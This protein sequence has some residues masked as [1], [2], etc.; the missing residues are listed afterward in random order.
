MS[1]SDEVERI[2][3]RKAEELRQREREDAPCEES[4]A[5][6]SD[7]PIAVD[8]ADHLAALAGRHDVL[9]VDFYADWCGPCQTMGPVVASIAAE[10]PAAVA[11]VD[12][13]R[14][15]TLASERD[16]RGVPTFVLYV[17]GEPVERLVGAQDRA[18]FGRL[19]EAHA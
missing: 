13:D 1:D 18:T 16:V 3:E 4:K 6:S 11:K 17:D 8:D 12:I 2:R 15:Q 14:L 9:L 10:T 19:I 7:E 5:V